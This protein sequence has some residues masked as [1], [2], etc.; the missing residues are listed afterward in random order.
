MRRK[1]QFQTT[2]LSSLEIGALA[3][4]GFLMEA[5]FARIKA[6]LSY[7]LQ[8]YLTRRPAGFITQHQGA[9][10]ISHFCQIAD[11]AWQ[12]IF[13]TQRKYNER[14]DIDAII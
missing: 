7:G 9:A 4:V 12:G 5:L 14:E 2:T 6:L 11:A 10:H 3:L 1:N 8:N 13:A